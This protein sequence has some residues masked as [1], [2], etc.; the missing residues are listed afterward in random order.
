VVSL[1]SFHAFS[2]GPWKV[3]GSIRD[4]ALSLSLDTQFGLFGH[5]LS[6]PSTNCTFGGFEAHDK[7]VKSTA[8]MTNNA[9]SKEISVFMET[10]ERLAN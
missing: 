7:R 6:L 2:G 8:K 10:I 9:I 5:A 3:S 1:R 4:D